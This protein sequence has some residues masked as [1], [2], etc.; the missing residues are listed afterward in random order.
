MVRYFFLRFFVLAA[1]ALSITNA[2]DCNICGP[3]TDNEMGNPK[4]VVTINYENY[5]YK[6][7]CLKWQESRLLAEAWCEENILEYT[8][9]LCQCMTRDGIFL[10]DIPEPTASP[11]PT[12]EAPPPTNRNDV[13]EVPTIGSPTGNNGPGTTSDA[14]RRRTAAMAGLLFSLLVL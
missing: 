12:Y 3:G 1:T 5:D 6:Q 14:Q 10:K 11:A 9:T 13:G 2:L 8:K 4:G 7:N